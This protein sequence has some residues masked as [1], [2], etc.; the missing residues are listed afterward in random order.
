[1]NI[2]NTSCFKHDDKSFVVCFG[3]LKNNVNIA[4][5]IINTLKC[6]N[7]DG[8]TIDIKLQHREDLIIIEMEKGHSDIINIKTSKQEFKNVV[9]HFPFEN[10]FEG[11]NTDINII[12]TMCRMYNFRLDE[13]IRYHLDLGVDKI[14]IFNN[15]KN[16]SP[17]NK[18]DQDN[19]PDMSKVTNKYGNKVLVVDFPYRAL[20]AH[21]WNTVQSLS[22]FI[23][24]HAMKKKAK[25]I[26]FTDADEF[27]VVVNNDIKSFCANN[28]RT[29]QL[30]SKFLTNK[31]DNDV[32]DNN[33]LQI[34]KYVGKDSIKKMMI[35]TENYYSNNPFFCFFNPHTTQ[36]KMNHARDVFFY[37][38]WV[39]NRLKYDESMK[40]INL[41]D[42]EKKEDNYV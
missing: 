5:E 31:G 27:L 15:T 24:L 3:S 9:L 40:Y 19:D 17:N 20:R 18:G 11:F 34:C 13:W 39:N 6:T 25:Y 36:H 32:I 16:G 37:H 28:N 38:C 12:S 23:G 1:M 10:A 42:K 8:S 22:L 35:Y 26:T 41:L 21:N 4:K 30:H 7:E 2:I 14:V 29:F 33:I